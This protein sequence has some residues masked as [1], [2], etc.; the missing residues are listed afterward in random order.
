MKKETLSF[1]VIAPI[2]IFTELSEK[3]KISKE[4]C[5]RLIALF[6]LQVN[7][8]NKDAALPKVTCEHHLNLC[9]VG[10]REYILTPL[11]LR[12]VPSRKRDRLATSSTKTLIHPLRYKIGFAH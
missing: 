10:F 1:E 8:I 9:H 4:D 5:V 7:M 11:C 3:A 2:S 12:R 6:S